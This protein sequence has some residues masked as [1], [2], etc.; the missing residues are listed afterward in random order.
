VLVA[1]GEQARLTAL[2]AEREGVEPECIHLCADVDSALE[3]VRATARPGDLVLVKGSRAARL[4]R[5]AAALRSARLE[6]TSA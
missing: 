6:G 2:G 5:V 3:V 4:E 1:V